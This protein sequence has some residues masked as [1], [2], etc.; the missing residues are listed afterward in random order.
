MLQLTKEQKENSF[1]NI[2]QEAF[3]PVCSN[4]DIDKTFAHDL[5]VILRATKY[6]ENPT[7]QQE[8]LEFCLAA[9][10]ARY[11]ESKISYLIE[12]DLQ[13]ALNQAFYKNQ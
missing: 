5:K 10:I 3:T 4:T 13:K 8:I 9:L 6:I 7:T 2:L 11:A 1:N 12:T